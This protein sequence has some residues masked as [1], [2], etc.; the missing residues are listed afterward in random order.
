VIAATARRHGSGSGAPSS[1]ATAGSA[2]S[3]DAAAPASPR[4]SITSFQPQ[5]DPHLFFD[6]TNLQAACR[7]CNYGDGA[8]VRA[9][10]RTNRQLVDHLQSVVE[11]QAAE[12]EELRRELDERSEANG[13]TRRAVPRIY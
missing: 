5:R 10:N 1:S 2:R 6:P 3:A 4:P 13:T 8:V 11:G 7:P 12:I 9:D